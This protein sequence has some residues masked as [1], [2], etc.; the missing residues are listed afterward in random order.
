MNPAHANHMPRNGRIARLLR[1][2]IWNN[3]T[4]IRLLSVP[5][6]LT[7]L[8][9][10][11]SQNILVRPGQ[12]RRAR[13]FPGIHIRPQRSASA[14]RTVHRVHTTSSR[15][16]PV[17]RGLCGRSPRT[18]PRLPPLLRC[19]PRLPRAWPAASFADARSP[20]RRC[21]SGTTSHV[22]CRSDE[23]PPCPGKFTRIHASASHFQPV[24]VSFAVGPAANYD[25]GYEFP[26]GQSGVFRA[27]TVRQHGRNLRAVE[28]RMTR[29]TRP[30]GGHE[31]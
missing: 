6:K 20:R 11:H 4:E 5:E 2:W 28:G 21:V 8:V 9:R 25:G 1:R 3:P 10:D 13:R 30:G 17:P 19:V 31:Q 14:E 24:R 29:S 7:L 18:G 23:Q 27:A 12:Q 22:L 26:A 16:E 15:F